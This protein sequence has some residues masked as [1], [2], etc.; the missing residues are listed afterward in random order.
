M[1][2]IWYRKDTSKATR[3][4]VSSVMLVKDTLPKQAAAGCHLRLPE[5]ALLQEPSC[6]AA[7]SATPRDTTELQCSK[8]FLPPKWFTQQFLSA[9]ASSATGGNFAWSRKNG[10]YF[11]LHT[12]KKD[13]PLIDKGYKEMVHYLY[14]IQLIIYSYLTY[15]IQRL[16]I[17]TF[18]L[19]NGHIDLPASIWKIKLFVTHSTSFALKGSFISHMEDSTLSTNNCAWC[20]SALLD[21]D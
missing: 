13:G 1:F 12:I 18:F 14:G 8:F 5:H 2:S 3:A 17:S 20:W 10:L 4:R 9:T 6:C 11:A 21:W 15:E 7:S 16:C 19:S